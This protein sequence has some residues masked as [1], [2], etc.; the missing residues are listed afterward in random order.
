MS[1]LTSPWPSPGDATPPLTGTFSTG[2][3]DT[4][5]IRSNAATSAGSKVSSETIATVWP[6]PWRP[7]DR[8]PPSSYTVSMMAGVIPPAGPAAIGPANAGR[9]VGRVS[10]PSTAATIPSS[11]AGMAGTSAGAW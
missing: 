9:S 3:P 5:A 6:S 4:P 7:S 10:S 2:G 11:A 1:R 8:S